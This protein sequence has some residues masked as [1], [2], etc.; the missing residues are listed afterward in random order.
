MRLCPVNDP[1]CRHPRRRQPELHY[2]G[3]ARG[4]V[5][6]ADHELREGMARF[7]R[8]RVPERVLHAKGAGAD[9]TRT[10]TRVS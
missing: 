1:L 10:V 2:R 7:N 5:L 4:P 8:E 6:M 9:G 3:P